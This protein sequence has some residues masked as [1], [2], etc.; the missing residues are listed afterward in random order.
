MSY[1]MKKVTSMVS[2]LVFIENEVVLELQKAEEDQLS[3]KQSSS[4]RQD[5]LSFGKGCMVG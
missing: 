1:M 3:N 5:K 2:D 4:M